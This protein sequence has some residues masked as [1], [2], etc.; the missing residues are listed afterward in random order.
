[1]VMIAETI[2]A[3]AI[4]MAVIMAEAT[5]AVIMA[6]AAAHRLQPVV[7]RLSVRGYSLSNS[8]V[9]TADRITSTAIRQSAYRQR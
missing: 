1:M 2:T 9:I 6:A 7:A 5:A 3:E 8:C 4:R